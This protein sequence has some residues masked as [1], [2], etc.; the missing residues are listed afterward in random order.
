MIISM[1]MRIMTSMVRSRKAH[2]LLLKKNFPDD[3]M[4]WIKLI[5]NKIKIKFLP[6]K[7]QIDDSISQ[8]REKI[9]IYMSDFENKSFIIPQNQELW[10]KKNNGENEII[11]Y[12]YENKKTKEKE[13]S[14]PHIFDINIEKNSKNLKIFDKNHLKKKYK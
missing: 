8:I 3:Y 10:L 1:A 13:F 9:Y 7:I 14:N 4:D 5:K 12:Y 6:I 2:Y 11:G